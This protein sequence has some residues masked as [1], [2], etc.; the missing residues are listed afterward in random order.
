MIAY[1][2]SIAI[3]RRFLNYRHILV[4][5]TKIILMTSILTMIH[6]E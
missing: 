6:D 4:N 2:K 3:Y 5:I 1:Q